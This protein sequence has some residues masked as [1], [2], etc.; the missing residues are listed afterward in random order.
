M[1]DMSDRFKDERDGPEDTRCD[2]CN[3]YE[4]FYYDGADLCED[5][6]YHRFEQLIINIANDW[7]VS[8]KVY[9]EINRVNEL[10]EMQCDI[11][12]SDKHM[13]FMGFALTFG[14]IEGREIALDEIEDK[15]K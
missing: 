12:R 8:H 13:D 7:I 14:N 6:W 10:E 4:S 15:E 5:C 1:Y 9:G 3:Y 2:R 11:L